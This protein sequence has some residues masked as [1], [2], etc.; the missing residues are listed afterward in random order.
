MPEDNTLPRSLVETLPASKD[1]AALVRKLDIAI[2]RLFDEARDRL[3]VDAVT[4][5]KGYVVL[6]RLND[7]LNELHRSDSSLGKFGKGFDRFKKEVVP[8]MMEQSGVTHIPLAEGWRVGVSSTLRAAIVADKRQEAFNWL[9]THG[10]EDLISSTVNAST[11]S[12]A[13]RHMMEDENRELPP[14]LF[15]VAVIPT[16]SLTRT[17]KK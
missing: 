15:N 6:S 4:L 8:A 10:L 17:K 14:D 12:A 5:A 13:A 7:M 3:A 11:L 9:R 2:D 16:T 1:V